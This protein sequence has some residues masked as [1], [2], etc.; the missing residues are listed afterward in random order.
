[1]GKIDKTGRSKFE[2][3]YIKL[4]H[5]IFDCWAWSQL[6][7]NARCAWTEIVRVYNGSNNGRLAVPVREL[8][9]TLHISKSEAARTLQE[10]TTFG[11]IEIAKRSSFAR[12]RLATEFRLTHLPCDLT[13]LLPPKT[14]MKIKPDSP[15]T[16]TMNG[17][18]HSPTEAS[19][20]PPQTLIGP[21]QVHHS[22]T[23]G[24]MGSIIPTTVPPQVLWRPKRGGP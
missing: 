6:S 21:L 15:T 18:I 19:I 24:T 13:G 8:A 17:K 9:D 22:P 1:M 14:F 16:G 2:G 10:L 12:K 23:H 7:A 3:N 4:P 5:Y 20:V 11:F